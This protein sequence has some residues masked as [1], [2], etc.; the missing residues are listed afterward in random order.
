MIDTVLPSATAPEEKLAVTEAR[1]TVSD[2]TFVSSVS[3]LEVIVAE[4]EPSYCLFD[5][6]KLPPIVKVFCVI[7]AVV[8]GAPTNV[9]E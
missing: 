2:P 9:S 4:S 8:V 6:A 7:F 3:E 5:T 1:V